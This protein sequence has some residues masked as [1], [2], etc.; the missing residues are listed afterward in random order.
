MEPSLP[1]CSV[2]HRAVPAALPE[3]SL[4]Q[5]SVTPPLV[6]SAPTGKF[7]F[8]YGFVCFLSAVLG[9][10]GCM[11]LSLATASRGCSLAV[12]YRLL[13]EAEHRLQ[14]M[15]ASAVA[16]C[17]LS[18]CSSQTLEHKLNSCGPRA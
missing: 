8:L 7:S 4:P 1:E 10:C 15:R 12:V 9:L 2:D 5:V 6:G 3:G 14:G 11:G 18:S 13:S 16:A 17:G